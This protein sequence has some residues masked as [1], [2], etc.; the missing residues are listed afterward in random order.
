MLGVAGQK[1]CVRLHG[2]LVWI[3]LCLK[4]RANGRHIVGQQLPTLMGVVASVCKKLKV[5]PVSNF[6]QQHA[7]GCAKGRNM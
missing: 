2:A 6:A 4:P 5:L 7:T 1:C 3:V